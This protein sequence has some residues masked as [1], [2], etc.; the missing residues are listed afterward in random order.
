MKNDSS[1][2]NVVDY[3]NIFSL[4]YKFMLLCIALLHSILL[5]TLCQL[6]PPA[7]RDYYKHQQAAVSLSMI[8]DFIHTFSR[9]C[10]LLVRSFLTLLS[11][12]SSN[13]NTHLG[14]KPSTIPVSR[15]YSSFRKQKI[16]FV[17]SS[18]PTKKQ[19]N[20][21]HPVPHATHPTAVKRHPKWK[22]SI[23]KL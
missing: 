5:F 17:C 19:N 13:N 15:K 20:L 11:S 18:H 10:V 6:H 22:D 8:Q 21:P 2:Q 16:G 23:S 7:R 12:F 3:I 4:I 1:K 9:F 14:R